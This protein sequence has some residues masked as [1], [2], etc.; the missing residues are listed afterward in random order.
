MM[1][2]KF[3]HALTVVPVVGA[4]LVLT[5][6]SSAFNPMG[7]NSYDCN[8]KQDPSSPF[9]HSFKAVEAS[10]NGELPDSRF[11]TEL[12][13]SDYDKATDI[14]PTGN[15]S[16]RSGGT[17]VLG[18]A[19]ETVSMGAAFSRAGA[20]ADSQGESA[21]EQLAALRAD[22]EQLKKQTLDKPTDTNV[23]ALVKAQHAL[24]EAASAAAGEGAP[25]RV[26]PVVQR[27][28]IKAFVDSNDSRI[29]STVVYREIIPT[30]WAGFD[31]SNPEAAQRGAYPHKTESTLIAAAHA[32]AQPH[33]QPLMQADSGHHNN[34]VQP[35]AN[36]DAGATEAPSN[37]T[38]MPQ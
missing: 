7:S 29:G 35:G 24:L 19:G 25:V 3:L 36:S 23:Q 38:N 8:R 22:V 20:A 1:L 26:G 21:N 11:D 34:F 33:A 10:T 6:C 18:G 27:T 28:W 9:C 14:A 2:K 32:A 12:K 4:V 13:F 5:G 37:S 16:G 30:H 31:G 17:G 15:A